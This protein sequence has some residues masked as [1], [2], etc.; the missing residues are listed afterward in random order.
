MV[1]SG[2]VLIVITTVLTVVMIGGEVLIRAFGRV[3][4]ET[5]WDIRSCFTQAVAIY[6]AVILG[7]NLAGAAVAFYR[8]HTQY[9]EFANQIGYFDYFIAAF[10]GVFFVGLILANTNITILNIGFFAFQDWLS[11]LKDPAL[12]SAV[13]RQAYLKR[14]L[15][16]K[17]K[18]EIKL[19]P[20]DELQN[21]FAKHLG[22]EELRKLEQD[23]GAMNIQDVELYKV[24]RLVELHPA[25][26]LM[27]SKRAKRRKRQ[28][29]S[30]GRM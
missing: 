11:S 7:C 28:R 3:G 2:L 24:M 17:L 19:L 8:L 14:V 26:A 20:S 5:G 25:E 1:A 23:A 22:R 27:L 10:A 30:R 12:A 6:F 9:P 18:D 29:R 15:Q 13:N 21:D 16:D 4:L